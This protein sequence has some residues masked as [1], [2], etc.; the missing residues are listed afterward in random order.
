MGILR[1][2]TLSGPQGAAPLTRLPLQVPRH[3][4]LVLGTSSLAAER[5]NVA[6]GGGIG[7]D[8]AAGEAAITTTTTEVSAMTVEAVEK[9][10]RF[11]PRCGYPA[12]CGLVC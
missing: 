5:S 12:G 10:T 1:R 7:F 8:G 3:L 2:N 9:H 4:A 6:E 11:F